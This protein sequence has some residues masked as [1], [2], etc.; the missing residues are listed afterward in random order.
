M[1]YSKNSIFAPDAIL[2][3][4]WGW[5]RWS[6]LQPSGSQVDDGLDWIGSNWTRNGAGTEANVCAR[7][8]YQTM[9]LHRLPMGSTCK[10][11]SG[12]DSRKKLE[13]DLDS[14]SSSRQHSANSTTT[15]TATT[16]TAQTRQSRP[17][18]CIFLFLQHSPPNPFNWEWFE[19]KIE[20]HTEPIQMK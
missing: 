4:C 1:R 13:S 3:A 17:A 8:T 19:W 5:E 11:T 12:T 9:H 7:V 16:T 6:E 2:K 20:G 18:I 14:N 10:R 15:T